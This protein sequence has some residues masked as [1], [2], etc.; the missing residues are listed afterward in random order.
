MLFA[1]NPAEI[2]DRIGTVVTVVDA[3]RDELTPR[4][5]S[6]ERRKPR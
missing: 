5:G 4:A 1:G 2:A 3:G 6:E